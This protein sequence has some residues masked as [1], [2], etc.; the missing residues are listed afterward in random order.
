MG[1]ELDIQ[2]LQPAVNINRVFLTRLEIS[3]PFCCDD[4]VAPKYEV[5]IEYRTYGVA[6]D[7]QRHFSG[8]S[9]EVHIKDFLTHA[10]AE[11]ANGDMTQLGA[12]Q[13]IE[14]AVA[15]IIADDLQT[16]ATLI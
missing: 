11:A 14:G 3:Q 12:L 2:N 16:T 7:G 15:A 8:E 4:L 6:P 10:Q 5:T 9:R 13:A 1:I